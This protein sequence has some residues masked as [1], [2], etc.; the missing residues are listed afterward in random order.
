MTMWTCYICGGC[1]PYENQRSR[2]TLSPYTDSAKGEVK[3]LLC[4][5]CGS[6]IEMDIEQR[7]RTVHHF[8]VIGE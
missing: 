6:T 3:F 2:V 4:K 5:P 1:L 7:R 8:S